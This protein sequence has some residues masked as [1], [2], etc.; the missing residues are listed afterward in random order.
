MLYRKESSSDPTNKPV[1]TSYFFPDGNLGRCGTMFGRFAVIEHGFWDSDDGDG[2]RRTVVLVYDVKN[3]GTLAKIC[4]LQQQRQNQENEDFDVAGTNIEHI[5]ILPKTAAGGPATIPRSSSKLYVDA[6][7]Q[8]KS[9]AL[10]VP[11]MKYTPLSLTSPQPQAEEDLQRLVDILSEGKILDNREEECDVDDEGGVLKVILP[12]GAALA[13]P[14]SIQSG[15]EQNDPTENPNPPPRSI[16]MGYRRPCGQ[17]QTIE[18][19]FDTP[20]WILR[21]VRA[22]YG[23]LAS[24]KK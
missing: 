24:N 6:Q 5:S 9:Q 13:C 4:F 3:G 20:Q 12:N 23:R 11:N 10:N 1:M 16:C 19:K 7:D 18:Y 2:M 14:W 15:E 21:R 17:I 8:Q 22:R